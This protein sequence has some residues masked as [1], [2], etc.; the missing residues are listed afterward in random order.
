MELQ[1]SAEDAAFRQSVRDF[2]DQALTPELRAEAARQ[3]G[4]FA[5]PGLARRW[6]GLLYKQG[7]IAPAWPTSFGG[8]DWSVVRRYIFEV[9]CALAGA[10]ALPG[11]GLQMCG[12]V[13][14]RY[15]TP[16]Q[17]NFFL[18]RILSGEHYWCQGYSEPQSGSDLASLQLRAERDGDDYVL[19]GSK[20]WTTHAHA[21][22]WIFV[23]ARTATDGRPQAGISFLLVDMA[24]PGLSVRPIISMSGE[25]EV[26]QVFFDDVRVPVS[27]RVGEENDGWTIAKFLLEH[28]RGGASQAA[29]V[30][31][32]LSQARRR[33]L[34]SSQ[35]AALAA[36]DIDA[37]ALAAT[38]QRL[39]SALSIQRG[40]TAASMIKVLGS[41][42]AQRATELLVDVIDH[43]AAAD[44]RAALQPGSNEP[45]IGPEDAA[46][47]TARYLNMRGASVYG[48]ANEVQR[49]ILAKIALG[50]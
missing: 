31:A 29:K 12:P 23:L 39:M 5:E 9:E 49:N 41:E 32:L 25:H 45:V 26:N 17:Q 10:P 22:N 15:G 28:E 50:L 44:Q 34:T 30:Q 19:N 27:R 18:P 6:H 3:A 40:D 21:A 8:C 4:V 42:L 36:L 1:L 2:L 20:I 16:A 13:L 35:R 43:Y 46:T 48:G 33:P 38:E 14:I 24:T 47:P 11:M 37:A 7:W